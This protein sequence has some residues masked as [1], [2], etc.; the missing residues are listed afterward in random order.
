MKYGFV[1]QTYETERIKVLSVWSEFR[2]EDLPVRP[3]PGDPRGRSVHEQMVH[4]CVSEDLWFRTIA[5][6]KWPCSACWVGI[7]TATTVQRQTRADWHKIRPPPFMPTPTLLPCSRERSQAGRRHYCPAA[8][9]SRSAS[10]PQQNKGGN[11]WTRTF[12][13]PEF[14][15]TSL[16][17]RRN[18]EGQP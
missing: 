14:L 7:C 13:V 17:D 11:F 10:V 15:D 1:L 2:D 12:G 8:R 6:S 3:R 5:G 9:A 4:Q 18:S 16:A